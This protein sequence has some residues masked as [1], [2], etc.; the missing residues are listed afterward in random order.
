M[1]ILF[2]NVT[3]NSFIMLLVLIAVL[4]GINEMT[5][6]S[7]ALSIAVYGLMPIVL[8][9]CI[10]LGIFGSPSGKTWF[11]WIK[12]ISALIGVWGFMFIRFT[13]WG[14]SKLMIWFPVTIL[15]VNI[16]EAVYKDLEVFRT[17]KTLEIDAAGITVLGGP[18]NIMNAIAGIL[19]IVTL[20][21]FAKIKVSKDKSRDMIWP[22]MTWMYI[23]GYTLWNF[24]YV[25]NCIST[26]SMYAGFAIL[27][28]AII[29]EYIFKRGAWL[30]HRAQT[31]SLF[32]LFSLCIDYQS[33][34]YFQIIPNYT[35]T[36]LMI[37]SGVAM[38]F[39][40]GA[41]IY[42]I[43]NMYKYKLNPIRESVYIHTKGYEKTIL[44]NNL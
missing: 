30:Q 21:G 18:W 40:M 41:F 24:A 17:Y 19:C 44:V 25:Y 12:A 3:L 10:K 7:K 38:V 27:L 6:R 34:G 35:E 39:N 16:L 11:G 33:I 31:L 14:Q 2:Y 13:K 36:N 29:A 42:M 22:D 37:I 28:S 20:S 5:R 32:A 8:V 1:G 26:R 43:Y 15:A 23:V 4:V 9:I